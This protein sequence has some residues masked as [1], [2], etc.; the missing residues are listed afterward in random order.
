MKIVSPKNCQAFFP[1]RFDL[2][3]LYLQP[4]MLSTPKDSSCLIRQD[5][6]T[7]DIIFH[8]AK[9]LSPYVHF[10]TSQMCIKQQEKTWKFVQSQ[11]QKSEFNIS[12]VN[13][14]I[15]D[16]FRTLFWQVYLH[17]IQWLKRVHFLGIWAKKL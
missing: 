12:R 11:K 14:L 6:M 10:F 2:Q 3:I 5:W 7:N 8:L 9:I 15:D 4:I 13:Q 1:I 17:L 16:A